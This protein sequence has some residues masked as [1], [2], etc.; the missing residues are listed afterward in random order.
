M[1]E[2]GVALAEED[3]AGF[4]SGIVIFICMGAGGAMILIS[5]IG[6]IGAIFKSSGTLYFVS[7]HIK[8]HVI[9]I[10]MMKG[11]PM[12]TQGNFVP[13]PGIKRKKN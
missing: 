12:L 4:D 9:L 2:D 1:N 13:K 8:E 11:W 6:L 5:I 3:V 7:I 10:H